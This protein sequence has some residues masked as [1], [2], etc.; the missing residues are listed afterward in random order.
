MLPVSWLK[1]EKTMSNRILLAGNPNVGKSTLFNAL[2][3]LKQHTGNWPGKTVQVAEG[4]VHYKGTD[5]TLVDLPGTY[6]LFSSSKE[7]QIASEAVCFLKHDCIVVVCDACALQRNMILLLQILQHTSQVVLCLN[8]IDEARR[9]QIHIDLQKLRELLPI[10]VVTTAAGKKQGLDDLMEA[11]IHTMERKDPSPFTIDYPF[12]LAHQLDHLQLPEGFDSDWMKLSL[13][14]DPDSTLSLWKKKGLSTEQEASCRRQALKS[15]PVLKQGMGDWKQTVVTTLI[16]ETEKICNEAVSLDERKVL[17][18]DQKID[19]ILFSRFLGIPL[20]LGLLCLSLWITISLANIP[21]QMLASFLFSLEAPLAHL[22]TSLHLPHFLVLMLSEGMYRVLA[23]VISVMLPPMAIFFPLFT[24]L[25]DLGYL[26]RV[27][28]NLDPFFAKAHACGKQALTSCMGLGCN[29]AGVTGCRIIDS[30]RE[31]LIAILTNSFIPCNGRFPTL[32]LILSLFFLQGQGLSHSFLSALVLSGLMILGLLISLLV[33][34]ILS[35]TVLKGI[36]SAF[37]LE[38]PSYRKPVLSKV[39]IRSCLDRTLKILYRAVIVAAP[40]GLVL[41]LC[42]QN[43]IQGQSVIMIL[44]SLLDPFGKLMGLDGAIL[45]AFL[46][47]FPANEIVFPI[48]LMIYM[49]N[50]SLMEFENVMMIRELLVSQGWTII[51]ALNMLIFVL[52]HW[53]CSTT[54]LTVYKETGKLKWT[55]LSFLLPTVTGILCCTAVNFILH[56]LLN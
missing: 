21:S 51:T 10:P 6:S 3:G 53:P 28:F 35:H 14:Y 26:P 50:S 18:Q 48:L 40:A 7:E 33:S 36:P 9:K 15:V 49:G 37:T 5:Y 41:W 39:I 12:V 24:Y 11:I 4:T 52:F 29:A 22:L 23:W 54:C 42:S 44:S 30:P 43:G 13:L 34:R 27:A 45:L 38:L 47:G 55:L 2:T 56:G 46:F 1:Q 20:M 17:E 16:H 32:I 31:R 19:R 8:L 25:E